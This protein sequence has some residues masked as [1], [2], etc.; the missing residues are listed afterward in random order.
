MLLMSKIKS[1]R[2]KEL[3]LLRK[4]DPK[5][6]TFGFLAN[7][8]RMSR[9][10]AHEIYHRE[11]NLERKKKVIVKWNRY[12]KKNKARALL[13]RAI[14]IGKIKKG[15][16]EDCGVRKTEGH[17]IDYNKPLRVKWLC[18]KHHRVIHR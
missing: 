8:F 1:E 6:Y 15:K 18:A 16:C 9:P 2:N 5:K 10:A 4:K 11:M 12:P 14:Q 13:R 17:H 7:H 3:V